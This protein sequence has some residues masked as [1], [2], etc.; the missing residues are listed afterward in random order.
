MMTL[1]LGASAAQGKQV[2]SATVAASK[3]I[4]RDFIVLSGN[5]ED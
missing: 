2:M 4:L 1:R 5:L 3:T